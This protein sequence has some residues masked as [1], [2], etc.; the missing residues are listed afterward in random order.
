MY[1]A[2][3]GKVSLLSFEACSNQAVCG[4]MPTDDNMTTYIRYHLASLYEHFIILSSGS[5]RDNISQDTIKNTI[6]PI[7]RIEILKKYEDIVKPIV[8]K[9]IANQ[10]EVE[11]LTKQRDELLPLLMNGQVSVNYHLYVSLYIDSLILNYTLNARLYERNFFRSCNP[12]IRIQF[13]SRANCDGSRDS[14][15]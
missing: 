10:K 6:L 11:N 13:Y 2:T 1:G 5:A 15:R 3:A 7:P 8:D 4:V 14:K 12:P 9:I